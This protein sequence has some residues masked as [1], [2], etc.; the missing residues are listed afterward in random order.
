MK[1]VLA[2][3]GWTLVPNTRLL[4]WLVGHANHRIRLNLNAWEHI[5]DIRPQRCLSYGSNAE[6]LAKHLAAYHSVCVCHLAAEGYC[7]KHGLVT[8]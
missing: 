8:D 3:Y 5:V 4:Y 6:D 2:Q 7:P 1:Q